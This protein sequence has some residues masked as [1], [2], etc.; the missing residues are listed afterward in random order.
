MGRMKPLR[1]WPAG[2]QSRRGLLSILY[3]QLSI[4]LLAACAAPSPAPAAVATAAPSAT[5]ARP[6]A[7]ARPATPSPAPPTATPA[8]EPLTVWVAEEEPAFVAARE[9]LEG[10]AAAI[11]VP[12]EVLA[13]PPDGVRLSLAT[14][15]LVGDPAPDLIWADQE[16]LVGLLTDGRLQPLDELPGGTPL[17]ALMTAAK[18]DG[19]LWGAPLAARGALLLLYN[20]AIVAAPPAT[21]DEL[22]VS[23][24]AAVTP[25]IAGLVMAWD[26]AR[27]LLPW[28][29]G[30]GGAP[31]S[32]D[33]QTITL[34]APATADAL[35]LL[36]ELQIAGEDETHNFGA[37]QRLFARGYAAMAIDGDWALEHYQAVS[38]TLELGIAPLPSVP[39]TGRPAIAPL[40]GTYLMLHRDLEGERLEQAHRL[41][42][43]LTVPKAQVA[44]ALALGRLPAL[45]DAL[46]DPALLADPALAAAAA[47]AAVAPGLPPTVAARCALFGIDVW[48]PAALAGT[49]TP[50]ETATRMQREAEACLERA[51]QG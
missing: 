24:R 50:A 13:R 39:A 45:S 36:R 47:G 12:L 16:A 25:E 10:A 23:A 43:A 19:E 38:D 33:G 11:G 34:D 30:F 20:R 7:T 32:A 8:P 27:W 17:P 22:I 3:L 41:I 40:G 51:A 44:L 29:Y 4:V 49:R 21:S 6:T 48:L 26:E 2:A 31:V 14:A 9:A 28:L 18:A 46:E 15:E 42:E 37:A 1:R 35:N 5:P